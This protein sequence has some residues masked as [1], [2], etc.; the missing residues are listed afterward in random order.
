MELIECHIRAWRQILAHYRR[1]PRFKHLKQI[2][3]LLGYLKHCEQVGE[4]LYDSYAQ[5]WRNDL[6][7]LIRRARE[8]DQL[9]LVSL[10]DALQHCQLP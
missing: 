3:H 5:E 10:Y 8:E 9:A 6:R 1:Q 4:L 2:T 7:L